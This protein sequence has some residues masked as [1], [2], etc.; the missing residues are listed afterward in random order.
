MLKWL[1]INLLQEEKQTYLRGR[2]QETIFLGNELD[3][4]SHVGIY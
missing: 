2:T 3:G 1:M 4:L